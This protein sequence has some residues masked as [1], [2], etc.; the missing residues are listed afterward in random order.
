MVSLAARTCPLGRDH[1]IRL[2][3]RLW[4]PAVPHRGAFSLASP[5]LTPHPPRRSRWSAASSSASTATNLGRLRCTEVD[6]HGAITTRYVSPGTAEMTTALYGLTPRDVRKLAASSL[7]HIR[8]RRSTVLLHLYH[9]KVLVQRDRIL[10][11]DDSASSASR[12]GLLRE[13]Q[14]GWL[15]QREAAAAAAA[16]AEAPGEEADADLFQEQQLTFEFHALEAVL[17]SVVSELEGELAAIRRSAECILRS[18]EEDVDRHTLITLLGLSNE[19]AQFSQQADLILDAVEG[20]LDRDDHVAALYLTAKAVA[21]EGGRAAMTEDDDLTVAERLLGSYY[22][23]YNEIVQEAQNLASEIRNTQESAS[24]ML[25]AT[26]NKMMLLD[27]Q[28]RIGTLGLASGSFF[29]AFYGMN[30]NSFIGETLWG[31][32]AVSGTSAVLAA[33]ALAYMLGVL[34]KLVRV[35]MKGHGEGASSMLG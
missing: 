9:V 23:A 19:V 7:S 26:R 29:A 3:Y 16:A 33:A 34:R 11:F 27:L 10:L 35:K 20:V 21:A 32:P 12:A 4:L 30:I 8:I 31:F 25:D 15:R 24:A 1:L 22:I 14:E 13:L 2:P 18:L 17:N 5:D 6:E 28:L